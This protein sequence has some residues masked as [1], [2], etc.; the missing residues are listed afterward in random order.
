SP[1]VPLA[2]WVYGAF[3]R[4]AA[5]GYV[6]N[7]FAGL[8]PWTRLE[9]ARLLGQAQEQLGGD[10]AGEA[11]AARV[12]S[13]LRDEVDREGELLGGGRNFGASLDSV[14]T[15]WTGISGTPLRD[16]YHFAQTL[17]NDSGR[18]YAAG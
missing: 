2:S 15:R 9:C 6:Q 12:V 13:A 10:D 8:R 16:G 14:Y 4:L 5:L 7:D 11:E 1:Y 18:P 17:V 3:D